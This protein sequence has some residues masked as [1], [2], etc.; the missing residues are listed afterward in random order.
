MEPTMLTQLTDD[1]S[2][3]LW[4][5]RNYIRG[6]Q[7]AIAA[8]YEWLGKWLFMFEDDLYPEDEEN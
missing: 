8:T 1:I 5:L 6:D 4:E 2:E 7:E 3:K